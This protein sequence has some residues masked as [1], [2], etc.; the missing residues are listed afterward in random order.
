[1][2]HLESQFEQRIAEALADDSESRGQRSRE[3]GPARVLIISADIQ[4]R[5]HAESLLVKRGH[6]ATVAASADEARSAMS[7]RRFDV[8]ILGPLSHDADGLDALSAWQRNSPASKTIV[9]SGVVSAAFAVEAMRAGAIDVLALPLEPAEFLQRVDAAMLK[10]RT[11]RDREQRLTRLKKICRELNVARHD[12]SKQVDALCDDL[13]HVYE[14]IADQMSDVSL[15]AEFRT[16][17]RQELDV[18][19]LLR[20][21]LEYLLTKTGPTN[22]AVFLPDGASLGGG[23]NGDH[24]NV[25]FGLGAYVN[26]DCPRETIS[27]MLD[28]LGEAICPQMAGENE[29]V[30]FADAEEF[31]EWI[32]TEAECLS[33]SQVIAFSCRHKGDCLAVI[34]LFR[35]QSQPFD[36]RLATMLDTM[37]TIIA[38]QLRNVVK[39]HHRAT[40]SWPREAEDGDLDFGLS[41]DNYGFGPQEGG[42]AA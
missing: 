29:I 21:T 28:H 18:E 17:L 7:G 42:L 32:G 12:I 37:R 19:D 33:D 41:D 16:L 1:M 4:V 38:E 36:E 8:V 3:A 13:A 39:V 27:A 6:H 20:T 23:A 15:A 10:S 34:V 5:G 24:R 2:E 30:R 25:T 14:D 26:C 40:P 35:K 22:A 31:S 9:L 11:D